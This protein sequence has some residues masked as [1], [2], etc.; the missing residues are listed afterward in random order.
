MAAAAGIAA[1]VSAGWWVWRKSDR[2]HWYRRLPGENALLLHV[3]FTALRRGASLL[4]LLE[5]KIDPDPDYASFIRRTGFDYQRDLD[6]A[7]VCY[8]PD[9]VYILAQGRFDPQR[10]RA[11]ALSQGGGCGGAA[12][13]A[14]PCHMPASRPDRKISFVL[15]ESGLL[16]L[17]T[18]P[19]PDAVLQLRREP[20][21]SALPLAAAARTANPRPALLWLTCGP[22][23]L[24]QLLPGNAAI[25]AGALSKAQRV[26]VFLNVL[27]AGL[28][29]LL[30]ADCASEA[31]AGETGRLL[32][33]L[34]KALEGALRAG[35]GERPP[36]EWEKVLA[37]TAIEQAGTVVRLSWSLDPS[38]LRSLAAATGAVSKG[39]IPDR[40]GGSSPA[41]ARPSGTGKD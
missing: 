20:A 39:S 6:E 22:S 23:T 19:E 38:T 16:A 17:A 27:P 4:P 2:D 31:Q 37:T 15:L 7:V 18:A 9:R 24:G 36:S 28:Q 8:L 3:H 12:L 14:E 5:A 41:P 25:L 10:L 1:A 29:L 30:H 35:R 11:Y 13:D 21:V 34:Q 32:K 26:H 40:K 33:G